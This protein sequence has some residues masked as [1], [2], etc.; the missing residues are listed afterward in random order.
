VSDRLALA[1]AIEDAGI[2]R[3]KAERVASVIIDAIHDNVAT[4]ADVQACET[5]VRGDLAGLRHDLQS[6]EARLDTK[7]MAVRADLTL[8]EHRLLTRLGGLMV[9][10]AGLLFA[11][12]RYWPPHG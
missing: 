9:V 12:L 3:A 4:K 2:E 8:V 5:A 6:S 11:A 7:I 10:L 1:N